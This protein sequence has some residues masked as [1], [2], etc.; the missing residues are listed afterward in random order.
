MHIRADLRRLLLRRSNAR[1]EIVA[2]S[3]RKLNCA[4]RAYGL[5]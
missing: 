5:P 2:V 3:T 1:S 4:V